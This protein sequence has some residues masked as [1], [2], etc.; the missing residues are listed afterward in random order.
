VVAGC[1]TKVPIKLCPEMA[2]HP[3]E[4]RSASKVD[5][6]RK[7]IYLHGF[8]NRELLFCH[9][10]SKANLVRAIHERVFR[11]K[12]EAG[13]QLPPRPEP[14][15]FS[16]RLT[17]IRRAF[18]QLMSDNYVPLSD[19]QFIAQVPAPK[20]RI[21]EAAM[22][23]WYVNG[24]HKGQCGV[25]AFVKFEKQ[26]EDDTKPDPAPRVI[27]TRSPVYHYRLGR[28]TRFIE[29]D[30]YKALENMWGGPTVM[31]GMNPNE[32]A[33]AIV[34][35]WRSFAKPVGIGL[36]ASRFDQ[37][38]SRDALKWEHEIY[39]RCFKDNAELR[40]L[41][42]QQL[43][44]VGY[45]DY[46]GGQLRYKT[47]GCR[48]SGDM[49]TGLGN[50][51]LMCCMMKAYVD[52][53]GVTARLINNGDDCVLIV[54]EADLVR[55]MDSYKQW[56]LD[57]GF[58]MTL[59]GDGI[60]YIPEQITF[61]QLQLVFTGEH[62]WTMVRQLKAVVKDAACLTPDLSGVPTWMGA[63]GECGLALAGDIPVYGA[64]Y[65]AY[66][67]MGDSNRRDGK[68]Q[69]VTIGHNAFRNT[70][71][72]LASKGMSRGSNGVPTDEARA[73]FYL[74]FGIEPALQRCLE[75]RFESITMVSSPTIEGFALH[76]LLPRD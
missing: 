64:I 75:H 49:N 9:N 38:V 3:G 50:C 7:Y 62:G 71:M 37:H 69:R 2:D 31:K 27:Q 59:E 36:D 28:Y 42:K 70:G 45:G 46:P 16:S 26:V 4:G 8:G 23:R 63:V 29:H 1:D 33:G 57:M 17:N 61:C 44:N 48:M 66:K 5:K 12:G 14:G 24:L 34:T 76:N 65:Q 51:L 11:V 74:A 53:L 43:E 39:S 22:R 58:K 20:R 15:V 6:S 47:C 13:L 60:A 73:S 32:V 72:A 41:L 21:Y 68:L 55:V 35:A 19:R 18:E 54:E 40:W 10:N 30:I 56:F 25:S 52:S 67:R